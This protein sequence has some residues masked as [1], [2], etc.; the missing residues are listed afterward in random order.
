M[1]IHVFFIF[2]YLLSAVFTDVG[3]CYLL[4]LHCLLVIYRKIVSGEKVD[5]LLLYCVNIIITSIANINMI[6][7]ANNGTVSTYYDYIIPEKINTSLVFWTLGNAFLFLGYDL[8]KSSSLPKINIDIKTPKN[9]RIVFWLMFILTFKYFLFD[10]LSLGSLGTILMVFASIGTL[11]MARLWGRT[12]ERVY[13]NYAIIL[14]VAQTAMAILYSYLRMEMVIPSICFT[15]GYVLGRGN[16]KA[17]LS[18]KFLP[19]VAF[20]LLFNNYFDVFGNYRTTIGVGVARLEGVNSKTVE[21]NTSIYTEE[22][23]QNI[24][25]RS[26]VLPQITNIVN[27]TETKGFYNGFALS[28]LITALIPRVLWPEKPLISLG[29][30]FA[31]EIGQSYE[32]EGQYTNSIN[33]TIPGHLYL[34]FGL[35]GVC[36]GCFIF[37][38]LLVL[39]WNSC[40]FYQS[41]YN[42]S[43]VVYG[44]YILIISLMGMGADLQI[45]VT[46]FSYYLIFFALKKFV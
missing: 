39:F 46:F 2:I 33:M 27:L 13:K 25:E 41:I 42:L 16:I 15:I 21:A 30:W 4:I 3:I 35:I 20:F 5:P 34:D 22:S 37:G 29:S 38:W 36:I 6:G 1:Q 8:F 43:G 17:V 12:N 7:N 14:V 11:F 28:P 40:E 24:L 44:G 26:S 19:I 31:N 32:V 18:A 10:V 9:I 23:K 45:I